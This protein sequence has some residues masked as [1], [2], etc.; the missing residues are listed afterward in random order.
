MI[1]NYRNNA[2]NCTLDGYGTLFPTLVILCTFKY[3]VS[4]IEIDC[5]GPSDFPI[6][7]GMGKCESYCEGVK[8]LITEI[9]GLRHVDTGYEEH[10]KLADIYTSFNTNKYPKKME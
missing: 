10:K 5:V 7:E 6:L 2:F 8:K 9:S 3:N 1:L 4:S